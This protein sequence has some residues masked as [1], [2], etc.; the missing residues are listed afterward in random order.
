[1]SEAAPKTV[2]LSYTSE[3]VEAATRICEALRTTARPYLNEAMSLLDEM[4]LVARQLVRA[5]ELIGWIT[6]AR[7]DLAGY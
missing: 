2:F 7:R 4:S 5:K 6:T 3:D 1:M